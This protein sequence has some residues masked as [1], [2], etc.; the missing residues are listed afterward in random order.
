MPDKRLIFPCGAY[1]PVSDDDSLLEQAHRAKDG[2]Y[3]IGVHPSSKPHLDEGGE[4]LMRVKL[5]HDIDYDGGRAP[6]LY[7]CPVKTRRKVE[8]GWDASGIH[9]WFISCHA[10]LCSQ[11]HI[12]EGDEGWYDITPIAPAKCP[13]CEEQRTYVQAC[14]RAAK[15]NEEAPDRDKWAKC[16]Q[17]EQYRELTLDTGLCSS[18]HLVKVVEANRG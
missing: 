17:C 12:D 6:C 13:H 16:P 15:H 10:R 2:A 1:F 9:G 18:C 8:R 11:E 5:R 3:R 7:F 14:R 4:C